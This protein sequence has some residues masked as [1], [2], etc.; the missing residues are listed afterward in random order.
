MR[1]SVPQDH[2]P[3]APATL[4]SMALRTAETRAASILTRSSGYLLGISSHSLQP[5]RGCSFGRSLCG[6]GCYVQHNAFLTRGERWGGFLEARSNAAELYAEHFERERRWARRT[7]G[8]FGIFLSSS[9]DPFVPQERKLGVTR[10]VLAAMC[11]EPPDELIVQTHSADV[12]RHGDALR[13]LAGRC[14]LRVQISI[15]SDCESLPGL[16][17]PA[18]SVDARFEAARALR[19]DGIFCV[20]CVAPL[21]PIADPR[22]FFERIGEAADAVVIDHFVGG[23]GSPDGAR[24]RRTA[25]PA[26]MEALVPGSSAPAYRDE[27]VAL[28]REALPGRVGV[29]R[30]GFAGRY[31]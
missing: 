6:V 27:I 17:R 16:P 1:R 14:A 8:A 29:C 18:S 7:R 22:A 20:I 24:T 5:Y 2:E 19:S 15:E 23:D 3:P 12:L 21:L 13:E 31:V 30:D 28:A 11:D 9:T 25:L 26:A 10:R 4:G